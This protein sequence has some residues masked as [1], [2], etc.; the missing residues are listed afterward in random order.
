MRANRQ[1]QEFALLL[2]DDDAVLP[3]R[4]FRSHLKDTA[5]TIVPGELCLDSLQ[6]I[7]TS[8]WG[9]Q[10]NQ[11]LWWMMKKAFVIRLK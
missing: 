5:N 11:Y 10:G 9:C 8:E 1:G 2:L 3:S 6:C 7:L 4:F